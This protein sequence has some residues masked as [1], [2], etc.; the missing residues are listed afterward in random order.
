MV[1]LRHGSFVGP[2]I[3]PN[4]RI[5]TGAKLLG[6]INVGAGARIGV[7]TPSWLSRVVEH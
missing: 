4:V 6:P 2:T 7:E 1:G 3:G 5:G